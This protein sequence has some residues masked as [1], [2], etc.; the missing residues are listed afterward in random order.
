MYCK[1]SS[2]LYILKVYIK[3]HRLVL[4]NM[5]NGSRLFVDREAAMLYMIRLVAEHLGMFPFVDELE[6]ER[7]DAAPQCYFLFVSKE[8][9]EVSEYVIHSLGIDNVLIDPKIAYPQALKT[10]VA[11]NKAYEINEE[12]EIVEP[13]K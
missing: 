3:L 6:R 12:N 1:D 5:Y 13:C 2:I 4:N 8:N 9:T 7:D 11:Y 10:Y